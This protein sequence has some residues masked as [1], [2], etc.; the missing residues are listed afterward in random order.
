MQRNSTWDKRSYVDR[1]ADTWVT[2]HDQAVNITQIDGYD[3]ITQHHVLLT[4]KSQ[5]N[6]LIALLQAALL[7]YSE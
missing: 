1:N 5:I 3:N 4:S 7:E 6:T 2:L